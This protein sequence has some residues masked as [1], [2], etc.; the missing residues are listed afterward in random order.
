MRAIGEVETRRSRVVPP[1]ARN[2]IL[3]LACLPISTRPQ[4]EK[5]A[6]DRGPFYLAE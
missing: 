1:S 5:A 3:S 4:K 2:E 6:N